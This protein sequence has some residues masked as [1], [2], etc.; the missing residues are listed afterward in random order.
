MQ[1][2][3]AVYDQIGFSLEHIARL[4]SRMGMTA[5]HSSGLN[6]GYAGHR[7]VTVGKF[8]LLQRRALDATLLCDRNADANQECDTSSDESFF[9]HDFR[10]FLDISSG[11][12]MRK[13][14]NGAG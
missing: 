4:N 12:R 11:A 10:P 3:F 2:G 14:A 9:D 1:G 8:D 7:V 6:F 5:G 13:A